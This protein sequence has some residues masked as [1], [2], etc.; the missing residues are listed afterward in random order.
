MS[1]YEF[2]RQIAS[3]DPKVLDACSKLDKLYK[4]IPE[5]KG[6][7]N[8]I[9][10]KDGC[11]GWC[12]LIQTPQLL[13]CEFLNIWN[14]I[15]NNWSNDEICDAIEKSMLNVIR[16]DTTKGCVFF[17]EE[18]K[19]CKI[20]NKRPY[21]C[22]IYG[23]TPDEE[24]KPRY[25]KIKELYKDIPSAIIKEQCDLVSTCD[26]SKTTIFKTNRWWK[27]LV[28][29]EKSIGIEEDDI[30]DKEGGSYRTPHDH[31]LLFLMPENVLSSLAGIRLYDKAEDRILAIK[32]LM[33][34][35]RNFYNKK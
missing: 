29:I 19:L 27:E 15:K 22:Y 3:S 17:N 1:I 16:G 14:Y 18:T 31:I 21:N 26:S 4:Q 2:Y 35:I 13:Y 30:N 6:C 11:G 9:N 8:N 28:K 33:S 20:H 25:E 23:I 5:T 32:E 24:F 10:K 12:C 7:L 34:H